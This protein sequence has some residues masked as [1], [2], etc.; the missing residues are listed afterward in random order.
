MRSEVQKSDC[1]EGS[2][3]LGRKSFVKGQRSPHL[4]A[5]RSQAKQAERDVVFERVAGEQCYDL[6]RSRESKMRAPVRRE[7]GNVG[8]EQPD[9]AGGRPHVAADLV[10]Q[11]G[12]ARAIWTDDQTPLA[13]PYRK[14]DVLCHG[15]SA[16]SLV[17]PDD[18]EGMWSHRALPRRA[19]ASRRKPGTIPVGITRTINKKTRPSSMFHRSI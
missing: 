5:R 10:E 14:R 16:E 7:K 3:G 19:A 13:G 9:L 18:L 17:Q 1:I 4:P 11:R 6:V 2:A 12:L 8:A 15:K